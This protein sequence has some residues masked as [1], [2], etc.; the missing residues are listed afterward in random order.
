M[1]RPAPAG[2]PGTA[3]I[4]PE[5]LRQVRRLEIRTR[6][7]VTELFGGEYHSAFKG[8]GMEFREVREYAWGDDVR[9]LDWNVTARTGV[10]HVKLFE[11][12]RELTVLLVAD[13]SASE[14]FGSGDRSKA[15]ALAELGAIMLMAALRNQDKVGLVLAT[16]HVELFVPPRKG[17][18]HALRV[19]RDLLWH[20][21]QGRG[22]DLGVALEELNRVQKRRAVV[23]LF[24]DFLAGNFGRP[25]R[26][27]ARR[28]DLVC[29]QLE[30]PRERELPDAGLLRLRDLESGT[31]GLV[32]SRE[33]GVRD[34]F[35]AQAIARQ[36]RLE[37][38]FASA[39]C[40]HLRVDVAGDLERPLHK[41]FLLREARR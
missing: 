40:D 35:A 28:H 19:L 8:K 41:F 36:K 38:E 5:L 27:A 3:P 30:D 15:R 9:A 20:P 31:V 17:R 6:R 37:R 25:L 26:V 13:L 2:A 10:P 16:D 34:A 11:E 29:V 14:R 23:F 21:L 4:P 18:G 32:D 39:G 22:T 7:R 1:E 24:S 12:E 33:A